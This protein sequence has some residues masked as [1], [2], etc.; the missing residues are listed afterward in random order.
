M[1]EYLAPGVYV[2]EVDTGSKPIEGVSTSTSGMVGITERGPV[3]EPTLVTGFADYTRRFGGFLDR[4]EFTGANWLFPHAIDGFFTNGGKRLYAVRVLPD[5]ATYATMRLFGAVTGGFSA[6]LASA[7]RRGERFVIVDD[8]TNLAA[9]DWVLVDDGLRTEYLEASSADA[10]ALRAPMPAGAP[11][12]DAVT[13]YTFAATGGGGALATNPTNATAAGDD[14]ILLDDTTGLTATGGDVLSIGTGDTVEFAVTSTANPADP[15]IAVTLASP[16]AFDHGTAENV[17]RVDG[18]PA[19]GTQLAQA[20]SIASWMIVVDDI[21]PL[22]GADAVALGAGTPTAYFTIGDLGIVGLPTY[23]RFRHAAGT[24]LVKP[25]LQDGG[26]ADRALQADAAAGDEELDI[27][28]RDDLAVGMLL[29][30]T[31][32]GGASEYVVIS[33]IDPAVGVGPDNPGKVT[34][35]NPLHLAYA[36]GDTA[37]PYQDAANDTDVTQIARAADAGDNVLLLVDR[38][39]HTPTDLVRIDAAVSPRVE[40][41]E[42]SAT[43]AAVVTFDADP[44]QTHPSGTALSEH[45]PVAHLQAIDRGAWGNDLRV[46]ALAEDR[47]TVSTV[48]TTGA[49][50]GDPS[51]VLRTGVGVEAGTLLEFM[52]GA[53][54]TFR[55]K[56]ESVSGG[57]VSFGAGGLEQ[58][59]VVD[60]VVQSA[61]FGL[62]VAYLRTNPRTQQ[63]EVDTSISESFRNLT[64]DP[65]HSRY[66]QRVIGQIP[67]TVDERNEGESSLIRVSDELAAAAAEAADR[68]TPDLLTRT[69]PDGEVVAV[70]LQLSDGDDQLG[71]LADSDLVGTDAVDPADRT[72]LQAL[73]NVNEI[74]IVAIPGRTSATVQNALLAH[75]ELTRYRFAVLD[76]VRGADPNGATLDQVQTQRS[77]FDSK[78]GALYYPWLVIDNPFPQNPAV[79]EPVM[80]PPSGHMIGIYARSDNERGVYKAPANEVV[81]G[82][83]AF[84]VKVVKEQQDI[85][86][87]RNV[88]VLR[89]FRDNGRGLRVWGART[90]SS[91]PD[92]RYLNVRRL[93]NFIEASIDIGTQWVVFEPNDFRLWTRVTQ[94]V[95]AF[96]TAVW[97]DGALMGR[98]P[99][100]AFYVKCDETTMSQYDIDNGRLIMV[101]GIA[102]VKPAEFV[103]IRIGQ[104]SGGSMVDEA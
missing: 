55:Q 71:A 12:A 21:T 56:V 101:I 25:D 102:P 36:T 76:A 74:S 23:L 44:L 73:K 86:N 2:E 68:A 38:T 11:E 63:V 65:R 100:Q 54:V 1:P 8:P 31:N 30:L 104:W 37:H 39:N 4:R 7:S 57:T 27:A 3:N 95:T 69:T 16:L 90:V 77:L 89:D 33:Q 29:L 96:L 14:Q 52:N 85:L 19:P 17:V 42:L 53:N 82:V 81:R 79:P 98:K 40:Y 6:M 67:A 92:W 18:T 24:S 80:I 99:E 26:A 59:V 10:L 32:A 83:N 62:D 84:Q 93:F 43:T 28:K 78:Y 49:N 50:I 5:A 46:T 9:G 22:A 94:S 61:E 75:A 97:H 51:I 45:T 20:A 91:D 64:L 15:T 41:F 34:L 88:N 60:T 87:P 66:I 72:G 48:V 13:P 103:V 35:T 58:N 47:P 70:G